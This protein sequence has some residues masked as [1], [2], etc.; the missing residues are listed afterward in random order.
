MSNKN[1]KTTCFSYKNNTHYTQEQGKHCKSKQLR[2]SCTKFKTRSI[3]ARYA[4]YF[5]AQPCIY[6]SWCIYCSG[7]IFFISSLRRGSDFLFACSLGDGR[8]LCSFHLLDRSRSLSSG[9]V[10]IIDT[11]FRLRSLRIFYFCF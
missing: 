2:A 7:S 4:L 3:L 1:P 6:C 8:R 5:N 10:G 9:V 11:S